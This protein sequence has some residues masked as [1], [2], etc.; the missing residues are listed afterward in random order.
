M[1]WLWMWQ[2]IVSKH[3]IV[4]D[5]CKSQHECTSL[6]WV[7]PHFCRE[8]GG[9]SFVQTVDTYY[10]N[11]Q[12]HI[13]EGCNLNTRFICLVNTEHILLTN[14]KCR[15]GLLFSLYSGHC[16]LAVGFSNTVIYLKM[17][18]EL[19]GWLDSKGL[20]R[21]CITLRIAGVWTLSIVRYSKN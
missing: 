14:H 4:P 20:W 18:G 19:S 15:C 3:Y 7:V 1:Y 21:W 6:C 16:V 5:G 8:Y 17:F 11:I 13:P 2:Y 9:S 12:C 10:Q